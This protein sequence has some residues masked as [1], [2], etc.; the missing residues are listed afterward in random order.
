M[1]ESKRKKLTLFFPVLPLL[2][3]AFS[4][5][6]AYAS[7]EGET[8]DQNNGM[9]TSNLSTSEN[10]AQENPS[11]E[12]QTIQDIVTNPPSSSIRLYGQ[13][14]EFVSGTP[15]KI[16]PPEVLRRL[17]ENQTNIQNGTRVVPEPPKEGQ[18]EVQV[19]GGKWIF[20]GYDKEDETIQDKDAHFTGKWEFE[21]APRQE[22][23]T[24]SK[25][26]SASSTP[27]KKT[28][29]AL[30]L[31]FTT[32]SFLLAILLVAISFLFY[33]RKKR[34]FANIKTPISSPTATSGDSQKQKNNSKAIWSHFTSVIDLLGFRR[35]KESDEDSWD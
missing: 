34:H 14:Y 28:K 32:I 30:T 35:R 8:T 3:F 22:T 4:P 20:K 11:P 2:F 33:Y 23:S 24:T 19:A 16:L 29:P 10:G 12:N 6:T 9:I 7:V 15:S 31:K 1:V 18:T 27:S 21:E 17:P 25:D 5:V 26:P 13:T